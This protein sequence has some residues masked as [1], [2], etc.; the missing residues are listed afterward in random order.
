M[1]MK[2]SFKLWATSITFGISGILT[3]ASCDA[4]EKEKETSEKMSVIP[5]DEK[6]S[7][8][9]PGTEQSCKDDKC[10]GGFELHILP[11]AGAYP[12]G[13]YQFAIS[14][15][16]EEHSAT[17]Q[18]EGNDAKCKVTGDSK[19]VVKVSF[20][21]HDENPEENDEWDGFVIEILERTA[22]GTS[23]RGPETISV[24]ITNEHSL[25][26]SETFN[27]EYDRT[28]PWGSLE[29]CGF[30][31]VMKAPLIMKVTLPEEESH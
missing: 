26:A 22:P 5:E 15:E 31:D 10:N 18:V 21:D 14:A 16:G 23:L 12:E 17:C 29:E 20:D 2:R 1:N 30:C 24:T 9:Q 4:T 6:S 13:E 11:T 25:M 27:P 28:T 8:E 19:F 3:A 7:S